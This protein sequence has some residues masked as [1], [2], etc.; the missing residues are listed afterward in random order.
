M[1]MLGFDIGSSS[2]KCAIVQA[3]TKTTIDL[4]QFRYQKHWYL[5]SDA[6]IGSCG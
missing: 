6:W 3:D 5:I 4:V 2:I 1:Y